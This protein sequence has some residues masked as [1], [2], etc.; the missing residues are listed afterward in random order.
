M[1]PK[2]SIEKTYIET[3]PELI[4]FILNSIKEIA[5][6]EFGTD[7]NESENVTVCDPFCGT[8]QF[9]ERGFATKIFQSDH[10]SD[11]IQM[12]INKNRADEARRKLEKNNVRTI[13]TDTLKLDYIP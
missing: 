4:D 1:K 9:F 8:G 7:L 2:D 11:M 13:N 10:K 5:K 3:P 6:D 12:E